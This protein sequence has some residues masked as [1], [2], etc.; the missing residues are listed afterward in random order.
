MMQLMMQLMVQLMMQLMMQLNEHKWLLYSL[1][2]VSRHG[3][4]SRLV[5]AMHVEELF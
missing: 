3:T 4:A 2:A 5:K 1:I